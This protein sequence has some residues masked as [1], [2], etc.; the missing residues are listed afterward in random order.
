MQVSDPTSPQYGQYLNQSEI[1]AIFNP[2]EDTVSNVTSWLQG[3]GARN[4]VPGHS[5]LHFTVRVDEANKML[6]T[7]FKVYT[8]DKTE[9]LRTTRYSV[10]DTMRHHVDII[11]P[12]PHFGNL[13]PQESK[14][15][16]ARLAHYQSDL[17]PSCVDY[18][19]LPNEDGET[20]NMP[21]LGPRCLSELYHTANYRPNPKSDSAV[22]FGS[23]AYQSASFS[24]LA[25]YEDRLNLNSSNFT[26]LASI[27]NG[28]TSQN[29]DKTFQNEGNLDV[30][31]IAGL[32][33]G[34]PI[35][36]YSTGGF[37]PLIPNAVFPNDT[38]DWNEPFL[39]HYEYLLAQ[40]EVGLPWVISHSYAD[41]ENTV[42][43]K[44]A[45][46]VCNLIGMLGLR[47]RTIL[48]SSG[49]MGV[50][51]LCRHDVPP[52]QPQFASQ[53]PG[54]CPYVTTVGDTQNY[55]PEIAWNESSGGFSFYFSQPWYQKEAVAECLS[56][57]IVPDTRDNYKLNN[58]IYLQG[59][60][61]PDISAHSMY[62][63]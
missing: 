26:I 54:S 18:V 38:Y 45:Q 24:D 28:T 11:I 50:G 17:D 41:Y 55:N 21:S 60:G 51:Q 15:L 9:K 49:D 58:Y 63:W 27:N 46:H 22:A 16:S 34:L 36:E 1:D 20:E 53:F 12:T 2:T 23:F 8:N 33:G 6:D 3:C 7:R 19:P 39:A 14:L 52:Y 61:F 32:V 5:D 59:R 30:Q 13:T 40:P 48:H 47:G 31:I 56:S 43:I 57:H 42:P 62:P 37:G 4:I 25:I 29:P 35:G 10:P 44:Y